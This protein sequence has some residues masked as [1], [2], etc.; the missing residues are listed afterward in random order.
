MVCPAALLPSCVPP[1]C[2]QLLPP[3]SDLSTA[4]WE[5]PNSLR[6]FSKQTVCIWL[7]LPADLKK[8]FLINKGHCISKVYSKQSNTLRHPLK[9][10]WSKS[11]TG[12]IW[13]RWIWLQK[14]QEAGRIS[15]SWYSL[16][17]SRLHFSLLD[18]TTLCRV[19][20][21]A[22][23]TPHQGRWEVAVGSCFPQMRYRV[24][25]K[26][27]ARS[28]TVP[29]PSSTTFHGPAGLA[30]GNALVPRGLCPP[31]SSCSLGRDAPAPGQLL[32]QPP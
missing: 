27:R 17:A 15:P 3:A 19:R 9:K 1:S 29:N 24:I 16:C 21:D 5:I 11:K 14:R 23:F 20:H 10:R 22:T 31:W 26:V 28:P 2:S 30:H 6:D 12:F 25:S 32:Q 7:I 8:P 18:I 13:R 4:T